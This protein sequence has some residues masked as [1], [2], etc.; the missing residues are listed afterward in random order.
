[1]PD[2]RIMTPEVWD[3]LPVFSNE[4]FTQIRYRV[5]GVT[6]PPANLVSAFAAD[7]GSLSLQ[8]IVTL[9]ACELWEKEHDDVDLFDGPF[10][11]VHSLSTSIDRHDDHIPDAGCNNWLGMCFREHAVDR[12]ADD[13]SEYARKH[14]MPRLP[15]SDE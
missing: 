8:P 12:Y 15:P 4:E 7:D 10:Y 1:M 14:P 11:Q 3:T 9:I 13:A 2:D 5:V 6:A